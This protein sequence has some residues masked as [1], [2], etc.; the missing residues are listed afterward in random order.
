MGTNNS[1]GDPDPH[2]YA[3]YEALKE[4]LQG[5]QWIQ[6]TS[7]KCNNTQGQTILELTD[8]VRALENKISELQTRIEWMENYDKEDNPNSNDDSDL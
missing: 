3:K 1:H 7:C 4:V 5:N 6:P 2:I 8:R